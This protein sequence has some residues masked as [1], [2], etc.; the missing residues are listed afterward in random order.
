MSEV[1]GPYRAFPEEANRLVATGLRSLSAESFVA[2]ARTLKGVPSDAAR[3]D[4]RRLLESFGPSSDIGRFRLFFR[5]LANGFLALQSNPALPR[6][7]TGMLQRSTFSSRFFVE[8][9]EEETPDVRE[10]GRARLGKYQ[11]VSLMTGNTALASK[12]VGDL[13]PVLTNA[14]LA[15]TLLTMLTQHG[16][17]KRLE[18]AETL[19]GCHNVLLKRAALALTHG[20]PPE[21]RARFLLRC[22]SEKPIAARAGALLAEAG[23]AALRPLTD[24]LQQNA[25]PARRIQL[26]RVMR[27]LRGLQPPRLLGD[28]ARDPDGNVAFWARV[29]LHAMGQDQTGY[30]REA[31]SF[32]DMHQRRIFAKREL[33]RTEVLKARM[34]VSELDH[35]DPIAHAYAA[36]AIGELENVEELVAPLVHTLTR[37]QDKS[38]R[39]AALQ[40]L[41]HFEDGRLY[42][43]LREAARD[44][45][46]EIRKRATAR[47]VALRGFSALEEHF[48]LG[49]VLTR[50]YDAMSFAQHRY[51]LFHVLP[52]LRHVP[53]YRFARYL[54]RLT[55]DTCDREIDY[56]F[57]VNLK[58]ILTAFGEAMTDELGE[59]ARSPNGN[60][61]SIA[62]ELLLRLPTRQAREM[63]EKARSSQD[64]LHVAYRNLRNAVLRTAAREE[65]ARAGRAAVPIVLPGL[66]DHELRA[67][68]CWI[69]GEVL[70]SAAIPKLIALLG[71][72]GDPKSGHE[73][74]TIARPRFFNGPVTYALVA[75]GE[76][77]AKHLKAPLASPDW[78]VRAH[79]A[80]IVGRIHDVPSLPTLR[81]LLT[82]QNPDV[83][84]AAM[85]AVAEM[86][87]EES[88]HTLANHL[89]SEHT[90]LMNA[91][92]QAL[93]TLGTPSALAVVEAA[94]PDMKDLSRRRMMQNALGRIRTRI[95]EAQTQSRSAVGNTIS[96]LFRKGEG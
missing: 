17:N 36:E 51:F 34:L 23:V 53:D 7:D 61:S 47:L 43:A 75:Y 25:D 81:A 40:R 66:D 37:S 62:E 55:R 72:C 5:A 83:A 50:E 86:K 1:Q 45:A 6:I 14:E 85:D 21:H 46:P 18:M 56:D 89:R 59:L 8:S 24:A 67:D 58:P 80:C 70:D 48:D 9:L 84:L 39:L 42:E 27:R 15:G 2:L 95:T 38:A 93:A 31:A 41:S 20:I 68:V 94:I 26:L 64:P 33:V 90:R 16:A 57:E 88:V 19:V 71:E 91:A 28:L 60:L 22:L 76:R 82:D 44:P 13:I 10:I 12:D 87:D 96:R 3:A 74:D 30:L 35:S 79:A 77:V 54:A 52:M 32:P 29:A 78:S 11:A 73:S 69:L 4:L 49:P 63:V 92:V 65:L